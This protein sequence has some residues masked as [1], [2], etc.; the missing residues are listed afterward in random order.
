MRA[1]Q[2]QTREPA[3]LQAVTTEYA[4]LQRLVEDQAPHHVT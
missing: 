2:N 3:D 1:A 4:T